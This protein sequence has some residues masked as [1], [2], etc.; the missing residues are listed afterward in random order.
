MR[1]VDLLNPLFIAKVN[2]RRSGYLGFIYEMA[3]ILWHVVVELSRLLANLAQLWIITRFQLGCLFLYCTYR[4]RLNIA[5]P[6]L[7]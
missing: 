5:Q 3:I 6:D 1:P 7:I 2:K 4:T